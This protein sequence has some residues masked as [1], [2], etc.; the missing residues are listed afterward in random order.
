MTLMK[1]NQMQ[2]ILHPLLLGLSQFLVCSICTLHLWLTD[3]CGQILPVQPCDGKHRALWDSCMCI[4]R[5]ALHPYRSV[6]SVI[7]TVLF[8]TNSKSIKLT[9]TLYVRVFIQACMSPRIT[10]IP[11]M[12]PHQLCNKP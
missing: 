1:N 9:S 5:S 7:V 6:K 8:I 11:I 12:I 3:C 10:R 4:C 2:R